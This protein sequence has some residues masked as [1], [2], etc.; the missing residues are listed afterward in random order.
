MFDNR[1][2][3]RDN[4]ITTKFAQLQNIVRYIGTEMVLEAGHRDK[5]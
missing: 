3:L 5:T 4:H 2:K 1:D